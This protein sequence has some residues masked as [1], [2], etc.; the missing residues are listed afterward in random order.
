MGS[1]GRKSAAELAVIAPA[2][3][4]SI[5]VAGTSSGLPPPTD[6][7]AVGKELWQQLTTEFTFEDTA[8]TQ[9]LYQACCAADRASK[10]RQ[11]ID[12][13]GEMVGPPDGVRRDHP[14]L[15]QELAARA[16]V[17]RTLANLFPPPR[18]EKPP[19]YRSSPGYYGG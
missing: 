2:K 15:K 17:V 19:R 3:P 7:G 9:Q 18:D 10:L 5:P 8:Q 6:L 13:D 4:V 16:F 14:C 11:H 12:R 1:R